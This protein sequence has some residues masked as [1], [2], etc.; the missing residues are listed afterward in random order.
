MEDQNM[1]LEEMQEIKT[2]YFIKFKEI[3]MIVMSESPEHYCERLKKALER[4]RPIT[5][6]DVEKDFPTVDENGFDIIY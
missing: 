4:G 6:E 1:S 3:P 2:E 5:E